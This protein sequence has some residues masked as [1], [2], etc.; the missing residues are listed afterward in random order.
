MFKRIILLITSVAIL[1]CS[2]ISDSSGPLPIDSRIESYQLNN[3]LNVYLMP[4]ERQGVEMRLVVHSGSMQEANNQQGLAHFVEHMAFKGT[5]DFPDKS[6]FKQL[7]Q[8]GINLGAHINAITS[9]NSTVYKLSLPNQTQQQVNLSLQVL[10]NWAFKLSFEPAAYES[11]RDII[12]EEWRLRQGVSYRINSKLDDLRYHGSLYQQR[13]PIGS[14]DIIKRGP[15]DSA[16]AYYQQWYQPQRMSLVVI[17][18]FNKQEVKEKIAAHFASQPRGESPQRSPQA[19]KFAQ[20]HQPMVTTIFDKEQGARFIQIMLQRNLEHTLN[21]FTGMQEDVIDQVWLSILS[22]RMTLMTENE[23]LPA[24]KVNEQSQLFDSQRVQYLM[25]IQPTTADYLTPIQRTF[26]EIHR[27]AQQPVTEQELAQVKQVLLNKLRQQEQTEQLYANDYLAQQVTVALENQLPLINKKQQRQLTEVQLAQLTPETLQSTLRSRL[28]QSDLRV[29]IVGPDSDAT[30]ISSQSVINAWSESATQAS[31]PF[32][33]QKQEVALHSANNTSG[34]I[35]SKRT[36][37]LKHGE[38]WTLSNG[39]RVIVYS[40]PTLE[41]NVQ[42]DLRIP[43]GSSTE[44][45]ARL[46]EL[47]WAQQL[48]ERSGYGDYSAHQLQQFSRQQRL[49]VRPYTELLAHGF[50]ATADSQQLDKLF[51]LMS[52]KLTAPKFDADKLATAKTQF[53][54]SY[55]KLPVERRF[56]DK[57]NE[58]SFSHSHRLLTDPQGVWRDFSAEQLRQR[59]TAA[60]TLTPQATLIVIGN[61]KPHEIESAIKQW[62]AGLPVQQGITH[63]WQDNHINPVMTS[64]AQ[65]YPMASSDKTMTSMLYSATAAWDPQTQLSLELIDHVVNLRLRYFVR[66]QASGVYAIIFSQQLMKLPTPY[67][68]A[69][70]NFTASPQRVKELQALAHD[71]VLKTASE[72]ISEKELALA[73]KAWLVDWQEKRASATYWVSALGQIAMDDNAFARLNQDKER[74]EKLT[75]SEVNHTARAVMGQN[76]KLYTLLPR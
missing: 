13:N 14:L 57:I 56:L 20:Q 39:L 64:F 31:S 35:K 40:D 70:L 37:P 71:I 2:T 42:I 6:S 16:M 74:V 47:S 59:Y 55:A 45:T 69:R 29:A 5:T 12:I 26:T 73:K 58:H 54:L 9:F 30:A 22:Q 75:V 23:R 7:E 1:G 49:Q 21:T 28:A 63:Q 67:Y 43:G 62:I 61:A 17:G 36:L 76:L 46:G 41:D 33:L 18:Q 4:R 66:E 38:E 60:F 3:G 24:T 53:A 65:N 32:T 72:G 15:M 11:E 48:A 10:A 68:L 25:F 52:L 19:G 34:S 27:L 51:Q 44:S 50:K 8:Y